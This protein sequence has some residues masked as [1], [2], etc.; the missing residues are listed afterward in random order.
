MILIGLLVGFSAF[1]ST[2]AENKDPKITLTVQATSVKTALELIGLSAHV[3]LLTTPQTAKDI[4][5]LRFVNVPLSEA[6]QRIAN[7]DD[8]EW[9]QERDGYRLIRPAKL[10]RAEQDFERNRAIQ[11]FSNALN[12]RRTQLQKLTP[13]SEQ[14]ADHYI[15]QI[16]ALIKDLP[17]TNP[18]PPWRKRG[19]Q[20]LLQS[21]FSRAIKELVATMDPVELAGIP[22]AFRTVWSSK[23][24]QTQRP[25]STLSQKIL[26]QYAQNDLIWKKAIVSHSV[27]PPTVTGNPFWTQQLATLLKTDR[28]SSPTFLLAFD[29]GRDFT[30]TA[31]DDD[32]KK[33]A[34]STDSLQGRLPTNDDSLKTLFNNPKEKPISLEGDSRLLT[35]FI[36]KGN[37]DERGTPPANLL[38]KLLDPERTDPLALTGSPLLVRVTEARNINM[39]ARL[40]DKLAVIDE[41]A[42]IRG[43]ESDASL[44]LGQY[45]DWGGLIDFHDGWLTVRPD[46]P[47][48]TRTIQVDRRA[49]GKYLNRLNRKTPLTIDEQASFIA[50]LPEFES[51]DLPF[52][53]ATYLNCPEAMFMDFPI[54]R[55]YAE[56][57]PQQRERMQTVGM[58]LASL[59]TREHELLNRMVYGLSY[60]LTYTP[61]P[62]IDGVTAI[63][64]ELY[65]SGILSD[66]TESLPSGLPPEGIVKVRVQNQPCVYEQTP[67]QKVHGMDQLLPD[68]L[69]MLIYAEKHPEEFKNNNPVAGRDFKHFM[70]GNRTTITL[71]FQFTPTLSMTG[72]LQDGNVTNL[73]S[74]P[75]EELPQTYKSEFEIAYDKWA[76][77]MAL[78]SAGTKGKAI[79]P[80]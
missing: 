55:F 27:T 61:P 16:Q 11:A 46:H 30:L 69:A 21:P 35:D 6:M 31:Y 71:T 29:N 5:S 2:L 42:A 47:A 3:T 34:S 57:T 70:V 14:E 78:R 25:F 68:H 77:M 58:P 39:I 44:A 73:K 23:P 41:I 75:Y 18:P 32:G 52:R 65:A 15:E 22:T 50:P 72:Y 36:R 12:E 76:R 19:Q 45:S 51:N 60:I 64:S 48:Q 80:P 40:P 17:T 79:P 38:A 10:E 54:L 13:W 28:H 43:Q 24:T 62:K 56:V 67:D 49:L 1:Q 8:A 4:V 26:E 66:A 37:I 33:I 7:V 63:D 53:Q 20:L 9:K 59:T 74:L